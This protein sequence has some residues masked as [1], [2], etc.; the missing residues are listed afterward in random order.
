MDID[1]GLDASERIESAFGGTSG[2]TSA[3][4]FHNLPSSSSE[5]L[6]SASTPEQG[7]TT[8]E[9]INTIGPNGEAIRGYKKTFTSSTT[10]TKTRSYGGAGSGV[11]GGSSG[12]LQLQSEGLRQSIS[13][14]PVRSSSSM[15]KLLNQEASSALHEH[16]ESCA[17]GHSHEHRHSSSSGHSKRPASSGEKAV[18]YSYRREEKRE[19]RSSTTPRESTRK[20]VKWSD[21]YHQQQANKENVIDLKDIDFLPD[22][23]LDKGKL[24]LF[25]FALLFS[26]TR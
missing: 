8:Y 4:T 1:S 18:Q 16:N 25:A 12:S 6:F 15:S 26:S 24:A 5:Q 11:S 2:T 9:E 13:P 7:S 10:S 21:A 19:S 22:P 17:S 14:I 23:D 20:N 3:S